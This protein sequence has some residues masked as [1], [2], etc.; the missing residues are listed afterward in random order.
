MTAWLVGEPSPRLC[1][2]SL[3]VVASVADV[4]DDFYLM[5]LAGRW[6]L[7]DKQARFTQFAVDFGA[8]YYRC[9]G[10]TEYLPK[11]FKGM[12]G[13]QLADLTAGW[14]RDAWL[15]AYRGFSVTLYERDPYLA[16]LLEDAL[17]N[18]RHNPRLAI[19]A[20][21]LTLCHGDALEKLDGLF[22][23]IYLD[24]MFPARQKRAQVKK[25]MQILHL[26]LGEET[27]DGA[28]LLE[29]ALLHA[30]KRVAVKRPR[31]APSL[32]ERKPHYRVEA[33][34]MRVD[35]YLPEQGKTNA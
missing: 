11:A 19:I 12:R 32:G 6:H 27:S 20:E 2:A 10:G 31:G 16:F 33:P 7:C 29:R 8:P 30:R 9:R 25:P 24:P 28:A 23:G 17:R 5:R 18:A 1:T 14:G 15:L 3:R 34:R 22:D 4:A 21:R 13:A 35:M 26:L